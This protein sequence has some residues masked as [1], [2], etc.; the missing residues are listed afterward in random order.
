M[1]WWTL[2]I[3]SVALEAFK[4]VRISFIAWAEIAA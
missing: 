3:T 1:W 2:V 4:S